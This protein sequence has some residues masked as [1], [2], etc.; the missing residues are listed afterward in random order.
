MGT[1]GPVQQGIQEAERK[2]VLERQDKAGIITPDETNELATIS[3]T[4]KA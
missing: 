4:D 2:A 3:Q 1:G